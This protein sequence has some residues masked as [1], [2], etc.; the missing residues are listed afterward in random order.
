[1]PYRGSAPAFT[2]VVSGQAQFTID[3]L[4]PAQPY[5]AAGRLRALASTDSGRTPGL[6]QIPA[7]AE[8]LPGYVVTNWYGMVLRAGTPAAMVERLHATVTQTLAEPDLRRRAGE[9]GLELVG[10][11][12]ETFGAL[13][14][15]AIE[16]WGAVVRRAG[17]RPD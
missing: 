12:R 16:R 2:D 10:G 5:L 6:P 4:A 11:Q 17:I 15:A 14:R 8:T 13:Q 9:L 3:A 1:M 7:A